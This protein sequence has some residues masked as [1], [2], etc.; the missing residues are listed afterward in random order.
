MPVNRT[1]TEIRA[2]ANHPS[3][4][5]PRAAS[6][7][8]TMKS[9]LPTSWVLSHTSSLLRVHGVKLWTEQ[10]PHVP[11]HRHKHNKKQSNEKNPIQSLEAQIKENS[12]NFK[13]K[14]T[15]IHI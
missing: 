15:N 12:M 14:L 10:G 1:G 2:S 9:Q 5:A 3:V 4:N 7:P 6:A 11:A 8:L 13:I